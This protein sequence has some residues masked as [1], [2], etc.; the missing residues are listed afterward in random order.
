MARI[1]VGGLHHETNSFA[2]HPADW[3]AFDQ[4]DGWPAHQRGAEMFGNVAGI[5]LA[6]T[7]FIDAATAHGHTL[8]P[9]VWANAGPSGPVTSD[10]FERLADEMLAELAAAGPLDGIFLDLHGAMITDA[11]GDGEG[12]LLARI[13]ALHPATPLVAALDL[14][15]NVSDA[16]VRHADGLVAYRT[17]PHVDIAETGARCL[18]LLERLIGGQKLAKAHRKLDFLI[19]LPWQC[20][21][22]EPSGG[23]YRLAD[24]LAARLDGFVSIAM[25]FPPGDTACGG[26][27]LLA[28][29]ERAEDAEAAVAELAAAFASVEPDFAGRLWTPEAAV[30]AALDGER[31]SRPVV[32]ADTQDNPGGGGTSDTTGLLAALIAAR[33]E[34]AMLALLADPQAARAA[35][36]AGAGAWLRGL[37]L[38]GRFGPSGVTPVTGDWYVQRLGNGRFT[39]TGPMYRGSRMDLGPMALLRAGSPDGPG[40]LVSTR[41]VQAADAAIFR[42]LGVEPAAQRILA[43]KSSVHFRAEFEP[44][45]AEVLV[46]AAPGVNTADPGLL[47]FR[48]L[49]ARVRRRP[50]Q[51]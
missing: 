23:L 14:H 27:S 26:P 28:Y 4:S 35:H 15:A 48:H 20:T 32:L 36:A 24:R 21:M 22:I 46:V 29:A 18:P 6:I 30:A 44:I 8:V 39:A 9:L 13:R 12:E 1:A 49:P 47:P 45:A 50:R 3:I 25:G 37:P 31:R 42:H 11:L 40:V 17:Y 51:S 7:G 43:L 5:N 41:R 34:D 10:A 38:G 33:A 16:M 2:P 19:G